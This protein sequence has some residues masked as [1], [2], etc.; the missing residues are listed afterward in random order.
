[1]EIL[2]HIF[3]VA[4]VLTTTIALIMAAIMLCI[5]VKDLLSG[6]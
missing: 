4:V 3:V 5:I 6:E 2:Y 1:M